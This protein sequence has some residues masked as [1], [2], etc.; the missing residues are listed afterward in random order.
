MPPPLL[1]DEDDKPFEAAEDLP[2][3][4][5]MLPQRPD[6]VPQVRASLLGDGRIFSCCVIPGSPYVC[7]GGA[8]SGDMFLWNTKTSKREK[9][10]VGHTA[11]VCSITYCPRRCVIYTGSFDC[12]AKQFCAITFEHRTTFEGHRGY[13]VALGLQEN[14]H[15]G[16]FFT[17]SD[18]M[19]IKQWNTDTGNI[20]GTFKG[21]GSS[22]NSLTCSDSYVFAG[23]V[24]GEIYVWNIAKRLLIRSFSA[25]TDTIWSLRLLP[26][27]RLISASG[28]T[29]IRIWDNPIV[30]TEMREEL[31]AHKGKV[32]CLVIHGPLLFSAGMDKVVFIWNLN[33]MRLVTCIQNIHVMGITTM[34][35]M[36]NELITGSFDRRINIFSVG[37]LL[38]VRQVDIALDFMEKEME[39]G[40]YS[41][42][43]RIDV[44]KRR[45]SNEQK[46]PDI[47]RA[48]RI[49][50]RPLADIVECYQEIPAKQVLTSLI[51]KVESS[52]LMTD[53]SIFV[54][55]VISFVFFFL[56]GSPVEEG[57][58]TV[59]AIENSLRVPILPNIRVDKTFG[60]MS[61]SGNWEAWVIGVLIPA[62][63]AGREVESNI[64][65]TIAGENYLL[66][67]LRFRTFR[68]SNSSCAANE[69]ILDT[70][71]FPGLGC[72]ANSLDDTAPYACKLGQ[73]TPDETLLA[74]LGK[75]PEGFNY[76]V[77][78]GPRFY[79]H[80]QS[81]PQGGYIVDIPLT[82]TLASATEKVKALKELGYVDSTATRFVAVQFMLYNPHLRGFIYSMFYMEATHA[83][84]W[85]P[86]SKTKAFQTFQQNLNTTL[87]EVY[88]MCFVLYFLGRYCARAK[89]SWNEGK[90]LHYLL[91]PWNLLE[92]VNI[93]IFL[94]MYGY[95]IGW[96][97]RSNSTVHEY[98]LPLMDNSL[99]PEKLELIAEAYITQVW[100]NAVNTV[101]T[102]LN[103]LKFCRL[104]DR[105]NILTR[106]LDAAQGNIVGVLLLFL[107]I[108][109]AFALT[110]NSL[111]GS[112]VF[113]YRSMDAAFN[114]L[115][116]MLMGDFDY[117]ELKLFQEQ[118]TI[119]F[120]WSYTVLALFI[121][122]NFLAAIIGDAFND[123]SSVA[124][125]AP[126]DEAIVKTV[127]DIW[128]MILPESIYR[129]YILLRHRKTHNA[130]ISKIIDEIILSRPLLAPIVH[131][132]AEP[133]QVDDSG[134]LVR[135]SKDEFMHFLDAETVELTGPEFIEQV[136]N[137][138]AWERHH[139][140]L[141]ESEG[142]K[143]DRNEYISNRV[144]LSLFRLKQVIAHTEH[145]SEK[146]EDLALKLGAFIHQA[147]EEEDGFGEEEEGDGFDEE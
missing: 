108:V 46:L 27:G 118:I 75:G 99:Y 13:V 136:W 69:E 40:A 91:D 80:L 25:H 85:I 33:S 72:Y 20:L 94:A 117:D 35:L 32:R 59:T 119:F 50:D 125:V 90:L 39:G 139:K 107:Y 103:I 78:K 124:G 36:S 56:L 11:V 122:L 21:H 83:G 87:Y 127:K 54:P 77:N 43:A 143:G 66:G 115:L 96:I 106:T 92:L 48:K 64:P 71:F 3:P 132:N 97:T 93:L 100:L 133:S 104:N 29:K 15:E 67:S 18:D 144:D 123:V 110:A 34:S 113:R 81:Y 57:Y 42:K 116:R 86:Y 79:G 19:T 4:P 126:L 62:L 142:S 14:V 65:N 58:H 140:L 84:T 105:L 30:S 102:F 22:V 131:E 23:T 128:S 51:M 8:P 55:F 1:V 147:E 141:S 76:T 112:A 134:P 28:D 61:N 138:L 68:A 5:Q 49:A 109:Y 70:S 145:L 2:N 44:M 45:L 130:V 38:P 9:I 31:L 120:F 129:N 52:K 37:D 82:D 74:M 98:K 95:R 53:L 114:A 121:L 41:V 137:D 10:I 101:L 6:Y 7:T 16:G 26:D 60:S 88:F 24:K 111:Y 47:E 12:T 63:Y 146:L 17:G 73:C 89:E 135:M